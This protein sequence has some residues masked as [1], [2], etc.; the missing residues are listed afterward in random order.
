MV[1]QWK[2]ERVF[3]DLE[4]RTRHSELKNGEVVLDEKVKQY[5]M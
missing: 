1:A 3:T 5:K 2:F 4:G